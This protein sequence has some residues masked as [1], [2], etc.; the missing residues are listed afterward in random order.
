MGKGTY[1]VCSFAISWKAVLALFNLFRRP[2]GTYRGKKRAVAWSLVL[3]FSQAR[4]VM[5][6]LH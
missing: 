6:L 2:W 4:L 1:F 5:D 3:T